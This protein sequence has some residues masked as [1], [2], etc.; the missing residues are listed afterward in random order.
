MVFKSRVF[1]GN[2]KTFYHT[3]WKDRFLRQTYIIENFS[4]RGSNT[5]FANILGIQE[6]HNGVEVDFKA[7]I[8]DYLKLNGM[9]S[10]GD[11]YY[12]GDASGTLLNENGN[13]ID[14]QGNEVPA[15]ELLNLNYTLDKAKVGQTAQ[16]NS[17]FRV[18]F[19][20]RFAKGLIF[21]I[22]WRYVDNLYAN[23]KYRYFFL[24]KK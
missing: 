3:T 19:P 23:F 14:L 9:F 7:T 24:K 16:T 12:K 8:T 1:S 17:C 20:P 10:F 11:W 6:I 13:A 15:V 4:G 22:D 5:G 2:F 18:V 21:D